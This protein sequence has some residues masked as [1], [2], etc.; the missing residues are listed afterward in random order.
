MR[1]ALALIRP[2]AAAL[3]W[4]LVC[5]AGVEAQYV[6]NPE[7]LSA[8][9]RNLERRPDDRPLDCSVSPLRPALNFGFRFQA[10]YTVR[11]PMQQ[12]AGKGH[13]WTILARVTPE[14]GAPVH[15]MARYGLPEIPQKTTQQL[16]VGGGYLVGEGSY[17]VAWK[18]Q[19]ETGRVC[20]KE[21]D[22]QAKR[23]RSESKVKVAME[24]NT[25][26]PVSAWVAGGGRAP[27]DAAPIRLTILMHAA[28]SSP[29]RTRMAAR[30]RF[31]LLGTLSS[32]LERL[33]TKSVRLVVF[34]LDQQKEL[35]RQDEFGPAGFND[36]AQALDGIELG[37]V[38]YQVLQNRRGHVD[39]LA[40]MVNQE[41]SAPEPSD[42]VLFL[43]PMSR[44]Y[45]KVPD[46][47]LD[48][49]A[50]SAPRFFYFQYRS[51]VMRMQATLPDTIH[52]AVSKLKGKT[53]IIHSPGDFAKGIDQVERFTR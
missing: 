19:D 45:D 42:V 28:P 53:V 11:V 1:R 6:V 21:W 3:A 44:Y 13:R 52:M 16:E 7:R 4:I 10:G 22:F 38:D 36:V 39:L 51:P 31:L 33:P 8:T 46:T 49:P 47:L 14:G 30:D 25:V 12:Y 24:P 15:F 18:L 34:N 20:R 26:A 43:G 37:S 17:K 5:A 41:V 2:A 50:G 27:D 32:L 29:R 9:T 48:K 35:Y 23:S 40:D